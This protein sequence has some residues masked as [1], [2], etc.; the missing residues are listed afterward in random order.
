M[1]ASAPASIAVRVGD[2][3]FANGDGEPKPSVVDG[4]L[5]AE[6]IADAWRERGYV[7]AVRMAE[8]GEPWPGDA[9][10]A[11]TFSGRQ[12]N[13]SSFWMQ[14]LNTLS[15]FVIPYHVDHQYELECLAE[16]V[17]TGAQHR[18]SVR[19]ADQTNVTLLLLVVAPWKGSG[20][21][22]AMENAGDHLWAD[23]ARQ[24]AFAP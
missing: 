17:A 12:R 1:P 14:A 18:A 2:F 6:E 23:L 15:L 19:A 3:T 11:V 20:H 16:N 8:D 13:D 5:L 9:A 10:W 24:G 7:S 4:R 22:S 21:R